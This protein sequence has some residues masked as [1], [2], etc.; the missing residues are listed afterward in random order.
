[1][2]LDNLGSK[3]LDNLTAKMGGCGTLCP[4]CR[5]PCE[6][7]AEAHK[8]HH[9]KINRSQGLGGYR[10]ESSK[11]LETDICTSSVFSDKS[12]KNVDTK[13]EWYPYKNYKAIYKDWEIPAD[14]SYEASDYWK[15]V[16]FKF[17]KDFADYYHAEPADIPDPWKT[18]SKWAA[19]KSLKEAFGHQ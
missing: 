18:I 6:A 13:G 14:E 3:P 16:M 19:R 8:V 11:K 5:S 4:F 2:K 17:N 9:V 7:G 10:D 12:F 15:Y 1:M